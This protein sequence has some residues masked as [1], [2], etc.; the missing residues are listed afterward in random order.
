MAIQNESENSRLENIQKYLQTIERRLSILEEEVGIS[1][2]RWRSIEEDK[3][4]SNRSISASR[5]TSS[6]G[7]E[8][9]FGES[10]LA[11]IGSIVFLFGITFLMQF[12]QAKGMNLLA[13]LI[14][15]FFAGSILL[16]SHYTRKSYTFLAVAFYYTASLLFYYVTL[17]THFFTD[18]PIIPGKI[19]AL[20][21]LTAVAAIVLIQAGRKQM[22][23]YS[24]LGLLMLGFTAIVSD[25][26]L[27]LLSLLALISMTATFFY[28]RYGW[29]RFLI[30][31]MVLTYISFLFWFLNNPLMGHQMQFIN[32][33][34][35]ALAFLF[36]IGA[37]FALIAVNSRRIRTSEQI[38]VAGIMV[39]G[40]FFTSLLALLVTSIYQDSYVLI[41]SLI[42]VYC[43]AYAIILKSISSWKFTSAFFALYGF[44]ALSITVFDIYGFPRVYWLLALQS[45]LVVSMALWFRNKFIVLMN[46]FLFIGLF[47][48]YLFSA[49]PLH[50]VNYAF[51]LVA[52][53]TARIINWKKDRLE[54][55]TEVVR[56]IYL[57]SAFFMLLFALY[58]TFTVNVITLSWT[59]MA[60]IFFIMSLAMKNVKYRYMALGTLIA[61]AIHLFIVDLARI[62]IV[63]R[64]VAFLFLA[65]ISIM[66]SIYYTR[67]IKKQKEGE[68]GN[69]IPAA[70]SKV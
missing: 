2:L 54:I 58:H 45:L 44:L 55:R 48:L 65:I 50:E 32:P 64:L 63:Y 36:F 3:D 14:G 56:N 29:W 30:Y 42:S 7:L 5:V 67:G 53:V 20:L 35:Y 59:I 68:E 69:D 52:L 11:W 39:N 31:S 28:F 10:G 12:V 16:V 25:S 49:E 19:L 24:G 37:I 62:D 57:F 38:A 70:E 40:L 6:R 23:V 46:V 33:P 18:H 34:N 61:A 17:R 47:I 9:G 51:A 26:S 43:L 27:Y 22:K 60:I 15:Y 13:T 8:S 66:I 1:S 41:F 21:L 4:E